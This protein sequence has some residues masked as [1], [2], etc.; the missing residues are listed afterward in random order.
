MNIVQWHRLWDFTH[1]ALPYG[2]VNSK[3]LIATKVQWETLRSMHSIAYCFH[4]EVSLCNKAFSMYNTWKTM[5][6]GVHKLQDAIDIEVLNPKSPSWTMLWYGFSKWDLAKAIRVVVHR[7][8]SQ[9]LVKIQVIYLRYVSL[10]P[11]LFLNGYQCTT[12]LDLHLEW[13]DVIHLRA[14]R[15][16][17]IW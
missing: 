7:Q 17:F 9:I 2:W 11:T 6:G 15:P 3:W 8:L 13:R 4:I 1:N 10:K 14:T 12:L 5:W 16:L